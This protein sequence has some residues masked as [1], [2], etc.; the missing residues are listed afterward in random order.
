MMDLQGLPL[1]VDGRY[2]VLELEPL[3]DLKPLAQ[4]VDMTLNGHQ[5][6][7]GHLA[8][9]DG[10]L[11]TIYAEVGWQLAQL[12]TAPVACGGLMLQVRVDVFFID[13]LH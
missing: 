7:E 11:L 9:G 4:D 10:Q 3:A 5:P 12:L 8:H 13:G 2:D 6:N 1:G